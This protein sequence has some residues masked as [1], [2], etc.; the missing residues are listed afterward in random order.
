MTKK[1]TLP[2]FV[3]IYLISLAAGFCFAGIRA[4]KAIAAA[5]TT[6]NTS[7][8]IMVRVDDMTVEHPRLVSVWAMFLTFLRDH[9]YFLN[10]CFRVRRLPT[11]IQAWEKRSTSPLTAPSPMNL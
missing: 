5:P 3:A 2:F 4:A 10:P 6:H 8:W 7:A 1:L 9:K 11:N